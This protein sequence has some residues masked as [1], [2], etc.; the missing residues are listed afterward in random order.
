MRRRTH[1]TSTELQ[2]WLTSTGDGATGAHVDRCEECQA[3]L[4]RLSGLDDELV[5]DLVTVLSVPRD[6]E[7]RTASRVEQRLRD[8]EA[9]G[10]LADLFGL[11]WSMFRLMTDVQGDV[12]E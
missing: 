1:P 2:H 5:A 6:I 9:V 4:E 12:H 3:E 11:G 8:E 7:V 10:V